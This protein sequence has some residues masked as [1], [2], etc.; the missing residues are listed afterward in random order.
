MKLSAMLDGYWLDKKR[1]FSKNT[2][3]N[4]T[5][6]FDYF[7]AFV[8]DVEFNTISTNDVRRFL[9]Y[10]ADAKEYSKRSVHDAWIPLSSL[11]TWAEAEEGTP[12][13]IRGKIAIPD[14]PEPVIEPFTQEEIKALLI[15]AEYSKPWETRNGKTAQSRRP[16]AE[17]DR[18]I[19]LTLLD[20]GIRAQ[21][22]CD[23]TITDYDSKRG[24]LHIQHGKGDKSRMVFVGMR[25]QKALWRY[26]SD[27]KAKHTDP[28]FATRSG[29]K[30]ERNNLRHTL[31]RIADQAEV[32]NVYPHRFRHT[33]AIN[34][35]RNGG[36]ILVLQA[37]LGHESLDT[38]QIYVKLAELDLERSQQ[39]S[40]VDNWKL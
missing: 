40:P 13:I 4:Y 36:N 1:E 14:F 24:R 12:H 26:L 11:W 17:R 25:S 39:H 27:R 15:A 28:L 18:A 29:E 30:M 7:L 21:E 33:F 16:T 23:L 34:Y 38:V 20:T 3:R 10:L 9:N 32:T 8:G 37:L 22:L 35:L 6:V 5:R 2:V 19:I 31:Q